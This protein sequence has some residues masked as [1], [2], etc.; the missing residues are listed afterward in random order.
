M[1]IK[2]KEIALE[3]Q[4]KAIKILKDP[5]INDYTRWEWERFFWLASTVLNDYCTK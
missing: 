1:E 3:L 4:Q 5:N 2:R